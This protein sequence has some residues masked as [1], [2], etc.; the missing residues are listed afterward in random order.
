MDT[1]DAD[2]GAPLDERL[3]QYHD[4]IAQ[5]FELAQDASLDDLKD[6]RKNA[7]ESFLAAVPKAVKRILYLMEHAEKDTTQLNAA[8][9]VVSSAL[10]KEGIGEAG[11]PLAQLLKELQAND[12]KQPNQADSDQ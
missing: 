4:A 1:P 8:K 7:A 11:D 2:N 10:A 9:Y 12:A 5:E 6:I 3:K